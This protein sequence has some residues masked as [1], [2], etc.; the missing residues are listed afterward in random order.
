M[1]MRLAV[2]T[3]VPFFFRNWLNQRN[4]HAATQTITYTIGKYSVE[5]PS[6]PIGWRRLGGDGRR[7]AG[8]LTATTWQLLFLHAWVVWAIC[9]VEELQNSEGSLLQF[10]GQKAQRKAFVS[11]YSMCSGVSESW[12][13][14]YF[15]SILSCCHYPIVVAVPFVYMYHTHW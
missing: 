2:E 8:I 7:S 9:Q 1:Q 13:S 12:I 10:E 3:R 4:A 11:T 14:F 6:F 5:S 15:Y